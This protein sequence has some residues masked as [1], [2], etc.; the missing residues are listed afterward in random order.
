M[1]AAGSC[2]ASP[3]FAVA[4]PFSSV[5]P[6]VMSVEL[7]V[8]VVRI[9]L[10][11]AAIVG[12]QACTDRPTEP[13]A[14]ANAPRPSSS[15]TRLECV[16]DVHAHTVACSAPK[17]KANTSAGPITLGGQGTYVQLTA[18]SVSYDPEASRFNALF[19]V[20][21]L[22][23]QKLG[24]FSGSDTM[25]V[26]VFL[27]SPAV[28]SDGSAVNLVNPDGFQM[29]TAA[30]QPFMHYQEILDAFGGT[31]RSR[32][33]SFHVASTAQ[34]FTFTV[35]VQAYSPEVDVPLRWDFERG[36]ATYSNHLVYGIDSRNV[37]A[38]G[39]RTDD[40]REGAPIFTADRF[41]GVAWHS[42]S[43]DF[44]VDVRAAWGSSASDLWVAGATGAVAHYNG[45]TWQHDTLA[46]GAF[47]LTGIWGSGASDVYVVGSD[48]CSNG[49]VEH[50]DGSAWSQVTAMPTAIYTAV[51]GTASNNVWAIG[52]AASSTVVAHFDGTQ[53][54]TVP[55]P[56]AGLPIGF[57]SL[58][59]AGSEV[60]AVGSGGSAHYDGSTWT[61]FPDPSA[62]LT[63][64]HG[65]DA[66]NVWAVGISS[67]GTLTLDIQVNV[68]LR[69][70]PGNKQ[71]ISGAQLASTLFF[72][73]WTSGPNDVWA[74]GEPFDIGTDGVPWHWDG[75][76]W[77]VVGTQAGIFTLFDHGP[78]SL[79][80]T[81]GIDANN[82]WAVGTSG[83]VLQNTG[84]GWHQ[85]G[86]QEFT[87]RWNGIWGS[88]ASDIWIVGD[89]ARVRHWDGTALQTILTPSS[90]AG[91]NLL[92][93]YGFAVS[94]LPSSDVYAVGD[95]G[96][97][98]HYNGTAWSEPANPTDCRLNAIWG[99]GPT[100]IWAVGACSEIA[101]FTGGAWSID[102]FSGPEL[103]AIAP[104]SDGIPV[105][106]GAG[107]AIYRRN[108]DGWLLQNS[109]TDA[110]LF[111][112][113]SDGPLGHMF[114]V[115]ARGTILRYTSSAWVPVSSGVS[116]DIRGAWMASAANIFAVGVG[117]FIAHGKP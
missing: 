54:T 66:T 111:G 91:E 92:A 24:T 72:S 14:N 22:T 48:C 15:A 46:L 99:S 61:V 56:D 30:N 34:Y 79:N 11:L 76:S 23:G 25:G 47:D 18:D 3:E 50:Y 13:L 20:Q 67:S 82:V 43:S 114:A 19:K 17:P 96:S 49:I 78:Q 28:S 112:L 94:G 69:W 5:S 113:I 108:T 68:A 81:F 21:N 2:S 45:S 12:L 32:L 105:A 89:G 74:L 104:G 37:F 33:W 40:S 109:N 27:N 70:D 85:V 71:W 65:S 107:G 59:A 29:F 102:P 97:I 1:A 64:V 7:H 60:W 106:V 53:W 87:A 101:H 44:G 83:Q 31:S 52:N 10:S 86:P 110:N 26:Y 62:A 77:T 93:V 41:D 35:L 9:A 103:F 73:V 115:G 57:V 63:A 39:S 6:P 58:Y 88:S 117:A 100:D 8:R 84:S 36:F 55:M 116:S 51:A 38:F 95:A 80:A 90:I 4:F 75:T 98:I 42:I 16:A